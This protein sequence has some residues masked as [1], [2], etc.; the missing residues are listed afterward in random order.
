[1]H[2]FET[3]GGIVC[4]PRIVVNGMRGKFEIIP[5][6]EFT[7][8]F[9]TQDRL[10]DAVGEEMRFGEPFLRVI[11][12]D[13]LPIFCDALAKAMFDGDPSLGHGRGECTCRVKKRGVSVVLA[14]VYVMC[15][16]AMDGKYGSTCVWIDEVPV[17]TLVRQIERKVGDG[18][19]KSGGLACGGDEADFLGDLDFL[20]G[21]GVAG[22][23]GGGGGSGAVPVPV[24]PPQDPRF[25][26]DLVDRQTAEMMPPDRRRYRHELASFEL[27]PSME[28]I[29]G[30]PHRDSNASG[31]SWSTGPP[32]VS[33]GSS[34]SGRL[35]SRGTTAAFT[36]EQLAGANADRSKRA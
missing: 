32:R 8:S 23:G 33:R 28:S 7:K 18:W 21:G 17:S 30:G 24:P 19:A 31:T 25:S 11:Y 13:D 5:N 20:G 9:M 27:A 10:E 12:P 22:G 16:Y 29:F 1:M 3:F 15:V 36:P 6:E 34:N 2:E 14:Q 26:F 35:S 4:G